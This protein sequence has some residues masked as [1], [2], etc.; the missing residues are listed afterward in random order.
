MKRLLLALAALSL[1][2]CIWD[3]TNRS[4]QASTVPIQ[5]DGYT[6]GS[7][8]L[9]TFT[10]KDFNTGAPAAPIG[11]VHAAMSPSFSSPY[12]FFAWSASPTPP[13]NFWAP[14]TV[15]ISGT[16]R[17]LNGL[18]TGP[19]RIELTASAGGTPFDTFSVAAKQ[20]AINDLNNGSTALAAGESRSDGQSL[21]V[22]ANYGVGSSAPAST[23]WNSAWTTD[24]CMNQPCD[25]GA[26]TCTYTGVD[27]T[28]PS[29]TWEIGHYTVQAKTIFGL[30][31]RPTTS[32]MHKAA[33]LNH[34]GFGG[35]DELALAYCL[36]SAAT[37]FVTVMSAYRG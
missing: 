5:L 34:S 19:G 29:T 9:V 18:A 16:P 15:T 8:D 30:L 22:F 20:L 11:S 7:N 36:G 13:P 14:Q 33:I 37:G 28:P 27:T 6:A 4:N 25:D 32:G 12:P 21:V 23:T 17:I 2:A 1:S 26:P 10:A 24:C 31:C 3:P 35:L